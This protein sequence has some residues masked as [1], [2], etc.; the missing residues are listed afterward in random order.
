MTAILNFSHNLGAK[1]K[2]YLCVICDFCKKK[3]VLD[4]GSIIFGGKWFH[5]NCFYRSDSTS[6]EPTLTKDLEPQYMT[7]NN[8]VEQND[9]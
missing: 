1:E 9:S 3:M 5:C 7:K 2:N 6:G 8:K 4:E